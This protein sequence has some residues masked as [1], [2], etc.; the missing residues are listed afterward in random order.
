ML[1]PVAWLIAG[2]ATAQAQLPERID[3]LNILSAELDFSDQPIPAE[4]FD[5]GSEPFHWIPPLPPPR[6]RASELNNRLTLASRGTLPLDVESSH[7]LRVHDLKLGGLGPVVIAYPDGHTESWDVRVELSSAVPQPIGELTLYPKPCEPAGHFSARVVLIPRL[8]FTRTTDGAERIWDLSNQPGGAWN[9]SIAQG[10][11]VAEPD[12]PP[13]TAARGGRHANPELSL[14]WGHRLISCSGD[15]GEAPTQRI[16][17]AFVLTGA[18]ATLILAP[19]RADLLAVDT[20][21]DQVPDPFDNAPLTA[22]TRQEDEDDDAIGDAADN[23]PSQPNF[24]QEDADRDG[25][26]DRCE[27]LPTTVLQF[28]DGLLRMDA[29]VGL[30]RPIKILQKTALSD[31]V[32]QPLATLHP[33]G[34][35]VALPLDRP[36]SFFTAAEN[37]CQCTNT[38]IVEL[39]E[40]EPVRTRL[41][42]G[43]TNWI[44]VRLA[45]KVQVFCTEDPTR[46]NCIGQIR[47]KIHKA[48]DPQWDNDATYPVYGSCKKS[49]TVLNLVAGFYDTVTNGNTYKGI[50]NIAYSAGCDPASLKPFRTISVA[51]D[52][53]KRTV[54]GSGL[55]DYIDYEK[56]DLDGDGL[57]GEQE[58]KLGTQDNS[59]DSNGN[60][61]PDIDEDPDGDGLTNGEEFRLGTD[62]LKDDTDG[63][64]VPDK[65][66][67]FP[68]DPTRP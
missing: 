64:K 42:S 3:T 24:C 22:N 63:D 34:G 46:R 10:H 19:S 68:L 31:A 26:G 25:R 62:P 21:V 11:W 61:T 45:M 33:G 40:P 52:F 66:D 7:S 12:A 39:K 14:L 65:K 59:N 44:Q 15:C 18:H 49:P 30:V 28:H 20:D 16:Q 35:G 27:P 6:G 29:P 41:F 58:T 57:T 13:A 36:Q 4:F 2:F 67:R 51:V 60:G 50:W 54:A 1:A 47:M 8:A 37:D 56:S 48:D 23:C 5:P 38:T 17:R 55:R 32:W 9:L 53:S 43:P